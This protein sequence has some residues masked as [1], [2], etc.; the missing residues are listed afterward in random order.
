M[1]HTSHKVCPITLWNP[2]KQSLVLEPLNT[3]KDG[4]MALSRPRRITCYLIVILRNGKR[5]I[6]V[7]NKTVMLEAQQII[8]I[9][10]NR[11]CCIEEPASS[12]AGVA[13]DGWLLAFDT[14]FFS[15]RYHLHKL[16]NFQIMS[17]ASGFTTGSLD[18][19]QFDQ[20]CQLLNA[21][22]LEITQRRSGGLE[23][24]R[25]YLNI[26]LFEFERSCQV[27][28]V[29]NTVISSKEEKVRQFEQLVEHDFSHQKGLSY[30]ADAL[31]ITGNY[32]NKLCHMVRGCSAGALLRRQAL[33]EA[34][35]RL[36]FTTGTVSEISHALGYAHPSYFITFFKKATG[37]TPEVFRKKEW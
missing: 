16:A 36:L 24:L 34:K 28:A 18:S 10:P 3:Y 5:Q 11:I 13:V 4:E 22:G 2:C 37:Y 9:Q 20:V 21:M 17:G 23:V 8:I 33:I 32:L 35:R 26:V 15:L 19:T 12:E 1:I 31:Y 30:Y 7:D 29:S 27:K 14:A 6:T 25:S